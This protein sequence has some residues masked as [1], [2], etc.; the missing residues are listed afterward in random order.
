[1]QLRVEFILGISFLKGL[2]MWE[3]PILKDRLNDWYTRRFNE[4]ELD[5]KF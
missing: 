5:K 4:F 1:M 3:R 2:L